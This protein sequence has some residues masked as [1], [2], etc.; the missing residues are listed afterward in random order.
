MS[1]SIILHENFE[2][3]SDP[4]SD[5]SL[6]ESIYL[7]QKYPNDNKFQQY[8]KNFDICT[9]DLLD[10][11]QSNEIADIS[12]QTQ[13]CVENCGK[14]NVKFNKKSYCVGC[15]I[16]SKWYCLICARKTKKE[17]SDFKKLKVAWICFNCEKP[18]NVLLN[19]RPQNENVPAEIDL[20][21]ENFLLKK[22][23]KNLIETNK[24]LIEKMEMVT[25]S[26]IIETVKELEDK[27]DILLNKLDG[28]HEK[29]KNNISSYSDVLRIDKI[30]TDPKEN[31]PV[32]ILK[33][34]KL[35]TNKETKHDLQK[36]INPIELNVSVNK[37]H[38]IKE[39]GIVI[40]SNSIENIEKLRKISEEK[41]NGKYKVQI[42]KLRSPKLVIV[43]CENPYKGNELLNDLIT[44]NYLD[45]EDR[46]EIKYIRK[47]K[48]LDKYIIYTEVSGRTFQKLVNKDIYLGWDKCKI[49]E[50]L[51]ILYCFKCCEYGH[52]AKEC[53]KKKICKFCA[54]EHS[55]WTCKE[56]TPKCVNCLISNTKFKTNYKYN[57]EA[58]NVEC[59]IHL[60]KVTKTKE[61]INYYAS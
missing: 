51:N 38:D 60:L 1:N 25:N 45:K 6:S 52:K 3:K 17:I 58:N 15:S 4:K 48:Y 2:A 23:I 19:I 34:K 14:C 41:L 5:E 18:T 46:L 28:I 59:S 32:L 49:R 31:I 57:H 27:M 22:L 21:E 24:N 54:K 47:S 61:K 9:Q 37:I 10:S 11:G 36:E 26:Q 56:Q 50:D 16:C 12:S 7:T 13:Q 35:Q 8:L 39:G 29:N 43:G 44:L 40:K 33:P 55:Y 42:S 30:K 53:L 20:K